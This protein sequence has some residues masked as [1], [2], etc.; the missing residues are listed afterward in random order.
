[1]SMKANEAWGVFERAVVA[2]HGLVP[3]NSGPEVSWDFPAPAAE[4]TNEWTQLLWNKAWIDSVQWHAED[5]IRDPHV[6]PTGALELKRRI[7]ALNQQRTDAVEFLDDYLENILRA[8]PVPSEPPTMRWLPT[9]TPAWALDR[10]SILALKIYHMSAEANRSN[11]DDEHRFRC[12]GKLEVLVR[13]KA[14]LIESIDALWHALCTQQ[15]PYRRYQQM[16]MYNDPTT[17]PV[18]YRTLD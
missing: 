5:R 8:L 16:K 2:Y 12:Q 4:A 11:A 1:M 15:A 18:L 10:L 6:A 14:E 17:N 3:D 13:Q 9:E 7:D